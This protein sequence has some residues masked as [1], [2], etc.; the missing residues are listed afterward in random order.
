MKIEVYSKDN[1]P[2]CAALKARLSKEGEAFT[3]INVG[4]DMT[5]EDFLA[6]FPQVRQMPHVEF[7]NEV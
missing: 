2:A 1:C 3:E 4:K 5:R 6:K 7:I